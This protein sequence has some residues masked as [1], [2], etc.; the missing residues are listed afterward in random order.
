MKKP[1]SPTWSESSRNQLLPVEAETANR[2]RERQEAS[3]GIATTK[4]SKPKGHATSARNSPTAH[5]DAASSHGNP[6]RSD[7][8]GPT[9]SCCST[10]LRQRQRHGDVLRLRRS[11]LDSI[12]SR[13][14]SRENGHAQDGWDDP[15]DFAPLLVPIGH[16]CR[17]HCSTSE[18]TTNRKEYTMTHT[19]IEMSEDNSTTSTR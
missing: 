4:P 17:N 19:L 15:D 5:P 3:S 14:R 18:S 10:R 11:R 8:R 2:R 9:R 7:S 16:N 6:P 12:D 1:T 13:C